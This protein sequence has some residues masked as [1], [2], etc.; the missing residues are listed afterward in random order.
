MSQEVLKQNTNKEQWKNWSSFAIKCIHIRELLKKLNISHPIWS[1]LNLSMS[2]PYNSSQQLIVSNKPMPNI[3]EPDKE[4][5]PCPNN[6]INNIG[7]YIASDRSRIGKKWDIA[8]LDLK[9]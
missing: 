9:L 2:P 7:V 5:T 1:K 6:R 3:P 8:T 4:K